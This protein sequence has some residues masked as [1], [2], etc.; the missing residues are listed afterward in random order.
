MSE[1]VVKRRY[2]VVGRV[3]N[4]GFRWWT[5][6]HARALGIVGT[7]RNHADGSVEVVAAGP[8]AAIEKLAT[9]IHSGPAGAKVDAVE[10]KPA[11]RQSFGET[12]EISG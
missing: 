11:P 7:V 12:F 8:A 5:A 1:E 2:R 3:Q 10:E 4:V 6:R 9:L